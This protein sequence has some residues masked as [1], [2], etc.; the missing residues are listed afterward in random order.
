MSGIVIFAPLEKFTEE[1]LHEFT[2]RYFTEDQLKE[3]EC[4]WMPITD[5][6]KALNESSIPVGQFDFVNAKG[7]H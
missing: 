6:F 1:E 7:I 2:F 3:M 5:F 4:D